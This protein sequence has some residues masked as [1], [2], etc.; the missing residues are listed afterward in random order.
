MP[1]ALIVLDGLGD[2]PNPESASR[3][4]L[5]AAHTPNLD[6]LAAR[7]QLGQVVLMGP[8]I[9]PESDAGVL[10]L[11]G[12]DPRTESPGRGVLEALGSGIDLSPGDVAWRLNFATSDGEGRIL[13]ARV[14]RSLSTSESSSLAR[15]LTEADLLEADRVRA[16][17]RSTVGHRGV[18]WMHPLDGRVLSAELSNSDPFYE[19]VGGTGQARKVSEPRLRPVRPLDSTPEAART[20]Q[21]VDRFLAAAAPVLAGHS[22][23]ARRAMSGKRVANALLLR[24]AGALPS[25]PARSFLERTGIEAAAVTEMP[26]ERGIARWLG[27]TDRFV[28]PMGPDRDAALA[29]RARITSSA[30]LEHEFVYVHLKGPDEPGHDGDAPA[31]KE[32]IEAL[33]RS[34]FGPFLDSEPWEMERIVVTAD[35]ATP[36]SLR[37]HSDDAVPLLLSGAGVAPGSRTATTNVTKFG[38][39]ACSRGPLGTM[40]GADVL[41]LLLRPERPA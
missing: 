34:F 33:D 30:L 26:V 5:E 7:G 41:P 36:C 20:A 37:A 10:S 1:R 6:A 22:T 39:G 18:L 40:R 19:K 27:M 17:V 21:L 9:A 32:V 16:E 12:L 8:G 38:E 35:H 3:T 2:R 14:G 24:S 28:G 11:L 29:D 25:V 15:S 4:P 23:N 31:K 13:D